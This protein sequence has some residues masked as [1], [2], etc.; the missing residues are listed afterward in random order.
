M[1][2]FSRLVYSTTFTKGRKLALMLTELREC[3]QHLT[4]PSVED[5]QQKDCIQAN[6]AIVTYL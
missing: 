1:K 6:W 5:Q 3:P 4:G 2:L